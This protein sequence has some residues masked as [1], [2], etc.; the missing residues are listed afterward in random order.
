MTLARPE[1]QLRLSL[2]SDDLL[3]SDLSWRIES[4]YIRANTWNEE[5]DSITLGLWGPVS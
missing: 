2:R 3:P 1:R 4:G 5:G